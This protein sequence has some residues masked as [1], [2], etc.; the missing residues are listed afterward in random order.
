MVMAHTGARQFG[1]LAPGGP[2]HLAG[3]AM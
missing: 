3:R 1:S 2:A